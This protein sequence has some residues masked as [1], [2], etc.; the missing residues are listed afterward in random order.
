MRTGWLP[1]LFVATALVIGSPAAA[2]NVAAAEL[3]VVPTP[4]KVE[5]Q[6]GTFAI[7]GNTQIILGEN[8]T[9]DEKFA[10]ED[11]RGALKEI[12]GFAIPFGT[13][14]EYRDNSIVIGKPETNPLVGELMKRKGLSF[15][16]K[17]NEQGYV[18]GIGEKGI[19]IAAESEAGVV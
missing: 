3:G 2:H 9:D 6:N 18:L 8:A 1:K 13:P 11:L 17:T 12:Y 14:G 10:A 4:Q 16:E 5:T 19:V 7:D 15:S